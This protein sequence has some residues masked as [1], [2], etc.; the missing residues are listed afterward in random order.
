MKACSSAPGKVI[1]LGEH[2]VVFGQPALVIAINRQ[3]T[4]KV[5][6]RKDKAL[7]LVSD[8]GISGIFENEKFRLENGGNDSKIF[9]EPVRIA[10][11]TVLDKF[12]VSQGFDI[13]IYSNIPAAAGL[14]SSSAI[15]VATVASIGK[16]IDVT[17]SQK[18]ICDLSLVSERFV[19]GNPSGVDPAIATYG[20]AIL[21]Q[22][23]EGIKRLQDLPTL[24]LVIGYTGLTRNTGDLVGAVRGRQIRLPTI[25][26]PL[27]ELAG[28]LTLNAVKALQDGDF[29]KLGECMDVNHGFLVAIGVSIIALDKLVDAA[30]RAGALGAKLTGAGGGGCMIALCAQGTQED[31]ANAIDKAGG[32]PLLVEKVET[33]IQTWMEK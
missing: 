24:S 29:H 32:T 11:Q 25:I 9:L 31:V 18:E 22:Q 13:E 19:H 30:K 10:A 2:F 28:K 20:G 17:L 26:D 3:V 12:E 23:R 1:L 33:G 4:V 27:I 7:R 5:S 21:Y 6:K 16:I 8:L 15:S 14:G